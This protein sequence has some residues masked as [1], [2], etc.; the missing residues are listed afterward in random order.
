MMADLETGDVVLRDRVAA[1]RVCGPRARARVER[2][3]HRKAAAL[4]P[5]WPAGLDLT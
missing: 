4:E 2:F 3:G 5:G 1:A